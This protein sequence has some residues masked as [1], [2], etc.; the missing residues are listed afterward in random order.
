MDSYRLVVSVGTG[1]V[2]FRGAGR[3]S[4]GDLSCSALLSRFV[5][6]FPFGARVRLSTISG[7]L[8]ELLRGADRETGFED[9]EGERIESV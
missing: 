2:E 1:Q 4:K 7:P 6:R 8:V 5:K 3:P 9:A